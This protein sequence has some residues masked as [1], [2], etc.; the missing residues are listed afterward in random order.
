MPDDGPGSDDLGARCGGGAHR[1]HARALRAPAVD[2]YRR[3][4][5]IREGW[6]AARAFGRWEDA[7]EL[8]PG[9]N[10][11]AAGGIWIAFKRRPSSCSIAQFCAARPTSEVP[12][13]QALGWDPTVAKHTAKERA[14]QQRARARVLDEDPRWRRGRLRD[15]IAARYVALEVYEAFSRV[16]RERDLEF[17]DIASGPTEIAPLHGFNAQRGHM[18]HAAHGRLIATR[19]PAGRRT[20]SSTSTR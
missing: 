5:G 2:R 4:A 9:G 19:R 7:T 16:L 11:V 18:D 6:R 20:T 10:G 15:V 1:R 8:R 17:S 3:V 12:R 14:E 13:L